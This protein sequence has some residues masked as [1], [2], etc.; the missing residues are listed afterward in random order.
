MVAVTPPSCILMQVI[1]GCNFSL[2]KHFLSLEVLKFPVL[3][4]PGGQQWL[5][6]FSGREWPEAHAVTAQ[7]Q[8]SRCLLPCC[9]GTLS[10]WKV[11][12][13]LCPE[14]TLGQAAVDWCDSGQAAA[15]CTQLMFACGER[16]VLA[17]V[18][19]PDS[20]ASVFMGR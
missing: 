7:P 14:R 15:G 11:E 10:E 9:L 8:T 6:S 1:W 19:R 2:L 12:Q 20:F 16:K 4:L 18:G 17:Q 3:I 13:I 5:L